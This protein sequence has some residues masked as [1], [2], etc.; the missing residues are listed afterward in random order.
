MEAVFTAT[1][2]AA[3]RRPAGTGT[4]VE[5]RDAAGLR[6]LLP[7]W[8]ALAA[9]AAEANPFYEPWMLLPALQAFGEGEGF[10][11]IAVWQD[12]TLSALFPMRLE[13]RFHGLPLR[14]LRSWSHRNMLHC[15]PLIRSKSAARCISALLHSGL[16]PVYHFDWTCVD[17]VFYGALAETVLAGGLPWMVTDAYMRPALVRGRDPREKFNSNTKNNLRRNETRLRAHGKL[18]PVRLA[19]GD[20]LQ[21][22]IEEFVR[23][24]ASG[25]KGR[26][27]SAIGCREDDRR[28]FGEVFAEAFRRE[29]LV[30]TGLDLEGKPLA[31]HVMLTAGEGCFSL[32]LAYDEA[33]EKSSPGLLAEV[34]NVR[35]FMEAAA[36][37]RWL[38][39]NTARESQGYGRVWKDS[40]TV[41]RI[42]VGVSAAGRL[43]VTGLPFMRLTKRF[44]RGM[45]RVRSGSDDAR[46]SA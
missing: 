34:D 41:H 22:W 40:R 20:D 39:S 13:R 2:P 17:G 24:E 15:T 33:H 31:R 42:A 5:V 32:K 44:L 36:G 12:G 4:I 30:I 18:S 23:L 11:C 37:P 16:A 3:V 45:R 29:R 35:Q 1:R 43:A 28:F 14:A 26:A 25:W 9:D 6:A 21:K 10:R 27:G 46:Q 19:P 7:D 8:E 38:D